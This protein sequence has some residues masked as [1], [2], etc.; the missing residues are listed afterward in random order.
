LTSDLRDEANPN[1]KTHLALNREQE[2]TSGHAKRT[3]EKIWPAKQKS[4]EYQAEN[5]IFRIGGGKNESLGTGRNNQVAAT[6]EKNISDLVTQSQEHKQ[7]KSNSSIEI[8][9]DSYN[10]RGHRPPSLIWLLESKMCSWLTSNIC[11]TK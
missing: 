6:K 7:L 4:E 10:H 8:Q 1:G 5:R 3:E 2:R 9:Q 11:N